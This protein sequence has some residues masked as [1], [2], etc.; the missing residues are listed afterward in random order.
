M[1]NSLLQTETESEAFPHPF[2]WTLPKFDRQNS[3]L[4]GFPFFIKGRMVQVDFRLRFRTDCGENMVGKKTK[5]G[6]KKQE[7]QAF[8]KTALKLRPAA[9]AVCI[10]L[11]TC[12][13]AFGAISTTTAFSGI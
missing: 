4:L 6:K 2:M 8:M 11:C 9:Q 7:C 10:C 1:V 12:S 3:R 5:K 13:R